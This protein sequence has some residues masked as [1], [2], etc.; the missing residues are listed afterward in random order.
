MLERVHHEPPKI[1]V[2]DFALLKSATRAATRAAGPIASVSRETR[3]DGGTLSRAGNV[4]E[5]N[6]IPIDDAVRVD[7]MSGDCRI[8]RMMAR[9]LG[10]RLVPINS[11]V[12]QPAL[13]HDAG[14][15]AREAGELVSEV[16]DASADNIITPTEARRADDEAADVEHCVQSIRK[17][18][19]GVI[20]PKHR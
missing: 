17:K 3:L 20:A 15:M 8:V 18:L 10:Y 11:P 13:M 6:F 4:N 1:E 12:E 5:T 16:I 19:H 14:T 7:A 9:M 2:S